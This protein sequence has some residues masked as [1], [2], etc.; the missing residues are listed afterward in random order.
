MRYLIPAQRIEFSEEIKKSR[1]IT[2]LAHT[3][4]L[5]HARAFWAEIKAQHPNARHWCWAAVAGSPDD[6]QQLGFS[7]DGEPSG[8]AG[9]PMLSA[10]QGANIGEISAVVVRYF[11][12]VLLGTGGLVRA[13][14]NGVQQA[15]SLLP[16]CEK[17]LRQKAQLI[18][19]YEQMPLVQQ[20][21]KQFD[22]LIDAQDFGSE[23]RFSLLL[24]PLSQA[25][26]AQQ[27]TDRSRGSLQLTLE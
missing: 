13:Y 20:L 24:D 1:F 27:L 7:D 15:L 12:G 4:G 26:F 17:I 23:V 11:G 16:T 9:K 19:P 14:G 10:L 6:C 3:E 22:V 21:I 18:C 25:Q 5:A 2:Y 8:T